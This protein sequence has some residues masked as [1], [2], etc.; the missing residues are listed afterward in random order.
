VESDG[1]ADAP[2][3][4]QH[5]YQQLLLLLYNIVFPLF[6]NICCFIFY[7]IL[8]HSSYLFLKNYYFN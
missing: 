4:A 1:P 7:I 3:A 2:C 6:L 8:N 5:M